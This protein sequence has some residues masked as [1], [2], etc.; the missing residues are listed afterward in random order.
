[1]KMKALIRRA[2]E[3]ML[4]TEFVMQAFFMV[5][6]I[7]LGKL[8][9]TVIFEN[10][11]GQLY[12]FVAQFITYGILGLAFGVISY[13]YKEKIEKA[14]SGKTQFKFILYTFMLVMVVSTVV[15][16]GRAYIEGM[17]SIESLIFSGATVLIIVC[18]LFGLAY[19][20]TAPILDKIDKECVEQLN[21][22]LNESK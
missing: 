22:K 1:M 18:G 3:G 19:L 12:Y 8:M 10:G 9:F 16:I 6:S 4:I 5:L 20:I 13:F 7:N 15:I 2:L 21:K 14:T 11:K 17:R